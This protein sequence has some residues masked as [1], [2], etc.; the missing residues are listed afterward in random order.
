[1]MKNHLDDGRQPEHQKMISF[2]MVN[3]LT[4]GRGPKQQKTWMME[5][6]LNLF[7]W[8]IIDGR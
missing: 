3:D 1:M 4:D 5:D 2:F 8:E 7:G 6:N